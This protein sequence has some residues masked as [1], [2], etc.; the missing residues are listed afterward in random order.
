MKQ[1][2]YEFFQKLFSTE[3]FPA[4]W[5]CGKWTDFHGW[6]YIMSD[7]GIWSAYFAIPLIL[8]YFVNKRKDTPFQPVFWLFIAF[9]FSCGATHL[10]DAIIFWEPIYRFSAMVR[11]ITALISWATV[12]TLIRVLPDALI[13]KSNK[14]WQEIS[15]KLETKNHQLENFSHIVSHNLRSPVGNLQ[16]LFDMYDDAKDEKEKQFIIQNIREVSN[17]LNSTVK[18]LTAIVKIR[19]DVDSLPMNQLTFEEILLHIKASLSVKIG[20]L[21]A[22]LTYNFDNCPVIYTSKV[23]LESIM[24]NLTTN[25]LKYH[26]PK[27]PPEIHWESREENDLIIL[28]CQDNGL[29]IDMERYGHQLFGLYKTF[30]RHKD[31]RGLGLFITKNQI[32]ALD[33]SIKAES[34]P[35]MGTKFII[36]F[37]KHE[38]ES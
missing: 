7:L 15:Q 38:P 6:F 22:K 26:S 14:Q 13:M 4:R 8:I 33:G 27:R 24:L 34:K 17:V 35:D 21:N 3:G 11:F 16:G 31:S 2:I 10:I 23:Y 28:T 18:D 36:S 37:K 5:F 12:F 25:A 9:I 29:G 1:G 30:H 19:Q 32:E 20:E